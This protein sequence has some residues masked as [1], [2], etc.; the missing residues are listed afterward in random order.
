MAYSIAKALGIDRPHTAQLAYF[1]AVWRGWGLI[2]QDGVA[3]LF[4]ASS[5]SAG[6]R[7]AMSRSDNFP[8]M[9]GMLCAN[10]IANGSMRP[11]AGCDHGRRFARP[12]IGI[13]R[14]HA[15]RKRDWRISCSGPAAK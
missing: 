8:L 7:P 6:Q 15:P 13:Q 10:M 4:S 14:N 12:G 1:A 11:V 2:D 3:S 9:S 5:A